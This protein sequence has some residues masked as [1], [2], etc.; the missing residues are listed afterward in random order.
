MTVRAGAEWR[1]CFVLPSIWLFNDPI[2][3]TYAIQFAWLVWSITFSNDEN[4][5]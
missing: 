5:F 4:F 3:S 1:Q 2:T